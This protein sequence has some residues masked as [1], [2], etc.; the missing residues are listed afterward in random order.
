MYLYEALKIMSNYIVKE[1]KC[2]SCGRMF[3]TT[4]NARKCSNCKY[5]VQRFGKRRYIKE[6]TREMRLK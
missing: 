2:Y 4:I 3:T 6:F 5:E 1:K